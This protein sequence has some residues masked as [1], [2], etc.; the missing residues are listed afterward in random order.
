MVAR[1]WLY[2]A[3]SVLCGVAAVVAGLLGV[4]DVVSVLSGGPSTGGKAPLLAM[5]RE[6][7]EWL[8]VVFVLGVG[9]AALLVAAVVSVLR[10]A[11]LHRDDRLV[12]V[13]D[14]L[15]HEFPVLREFDVAST[16]EPTTED[17]E[18]ELT[19]RYV[20]N[21]I[22]EDEF[23]REMERLLDDSSSND[24]SGSRT[25]TNLDGDW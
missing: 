14:R 7:L 24:R 9:A 15:E 4:L 17:R 22:A 16:V 11:S 20:A 2:A 5:L 10:N 21:E 6:A 23:E 12:S 25:E 19:E 3:G 1:H 13:V 18:H 8:V